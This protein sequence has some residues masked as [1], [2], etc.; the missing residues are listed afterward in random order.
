MVE[1]LILNEIQNKKKE[2]IEFLRKLI[3]TESYNPPGNEKNIA[4]IIDKYL[5][6][7]GLNSELYLFG[8]NRANLITRL[9]KNNIGKT[10]LFN[11]HMDV[12]PVES[13]E[14][15]KYPP[16][17]ATVKRNKTIFGRGAVDMKGGL[18]AMVIALTVLKKLQIKLSGNLILNAV[19]DEETG[20]ILGTKWTID[21]I[22]KSE[23]CNFV[24]IGEPSGFNPL[25]K[26]IIFGE[27]GHVVIKLIA[28][29]KSCHSSA[30]FLGKNAI[31]MMS[32]IIQHLDKLNDYIPKI[33]PPLSED[34]V[35]DLISITFPSREI[36]DRIL[37]EQPV[38]KN[39][40]KL[41]LD[42]TKNIT[43]IHGGVKPNIIPNKCEAMIDFRLLPGQSVDV[44]LKG[45]VN[46]INELGYQIK[47]ELITLN[48]EIFF[49]FEIQSQ[50]ES[51]YW[52]DW[53]ESAV[54]KDFYNIVE[55]TYKKKPFYFFLP[56]SA[57]AQFYRNTNFCQSTIMFGPGNIS[58]AHSNNEKIDIQDFINAIKVYSLFAY[59]FLK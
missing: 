56:G 5:R 9:N 25:P 40:L 36:F 52:N 20:G 1:E 43:M 6:E 47:D 16:L 7:Y 48:D 31:S 57:D 21:N 27:K 22:L 49:Y 15:W 23:K 2:Y 46:L 58:L 45:L 59:K 4:L 33:K 11:G 53:K 8:N 42:F 12:V 24:I 18:A 13:I 30:P 34:N 38:I 35:K 51:S 54:I 32:E 17:S 37:D 26:A 55:K 29:G 3:Q 50:S 41:N 10:L 44:I 39:L 14:G 28:I 19:A